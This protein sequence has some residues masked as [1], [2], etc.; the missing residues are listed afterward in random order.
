MED[1]ALIKHKSI[2][3]ERWTDNQKERLKDEQ[4]DRGIN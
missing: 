4:I 1:I 3:S 2:S